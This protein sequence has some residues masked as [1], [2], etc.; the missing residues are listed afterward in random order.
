LTKPQFST[1]AIS[2]LI[3]LFPCFTRWQVHW[4]GFHKVFKVLT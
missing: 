1:L 4:T 3:V 2:T